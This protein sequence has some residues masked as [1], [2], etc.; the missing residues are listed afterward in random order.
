[1]NL[2]MTTSQELIWA[3]RKPGSRFY[4]KNAYQE[5]Q[6][7][8]KSCEVCAKLK[9]PPANRDKFKSILEFAIR[10]DGSRHFRI[11]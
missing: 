7:Y 4:W 3:K 5:T 10:Y 2:V 8:V 1:M 6:E 9:S 11:V